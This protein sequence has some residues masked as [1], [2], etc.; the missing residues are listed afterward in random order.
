MSYLDELFSLKGKVAAVIGGSGVLGGAM[1][2]GLAK[3]GAK[4]AILGQTPEKIAARVTAI[5]NEAGEAL[6]VQC[7]ASEKLAVAAALETILSEWGQVD[8]LI[9][10]VPV[11]AHREGSNRFGLLAQARS[12]A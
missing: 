9:N 11:D 6:P 3:A 10:A 4:V 1:A 5:K 8:I 7:N 2:A 12:R